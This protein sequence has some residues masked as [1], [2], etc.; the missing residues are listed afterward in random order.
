VPTTGTHQLAG[1]LGSLGACGVLVAAASLLLGWEG[2]IAFAVLLLAG[3][4]VGA[5]YARGGRPDRW[6][7]LEAVGLLALAELCAWSIQLR[8]KVAQERAVV[9]ARLGSV[10]ALLAGSAVAAALVLATI[11]LPRAR[12]IEWAAMGT[13]A[14]VAVLSVIAVLSRR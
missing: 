3:E 12:G 7:L 1:L 8:I 10:A 9:L 11:G 14:A 6:S 2:L 5:L 4:Y 13:A